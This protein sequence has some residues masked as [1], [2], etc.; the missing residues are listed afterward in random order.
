MKNIGHEQSVVNPCMYFSRNKNGELAIWLSW[1]DD[2]LIV[3][4]WHVMK[5][6]DKKLAK[7]IEIEAIGELKEFVGFK[8]EI[9]KSEGSE[10]LP[11]LS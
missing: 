9:D 10:N 11:N 4:L 7:E 5:N 1:V 3:S 8:I 2:N 6:E